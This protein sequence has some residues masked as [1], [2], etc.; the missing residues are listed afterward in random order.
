MT[1]IREHHSLLAFV[2]RRLLVA[3]AG[4]LPRRLTS[5]HLT[6]LGLG[7]LAAAGASV[8]CLRARRAVSDPAAR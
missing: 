1:H 2:E 3:I 5:D 8:A 4:R 6:I 7:S